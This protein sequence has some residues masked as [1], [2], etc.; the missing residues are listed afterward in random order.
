MLLQLRL[1]EHVALAVPSTTAPEAKLMHPVNG[2][3]HGGC[4]GRGHW[5]S[6]GFAQCYR[7]SSVSYRFGPLHAQFIPSTSR[8][9][10]IPGPFGCAI[11][12][13]R[14]YARVVLGRD[15]P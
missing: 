13:M 6:A 9:G 3:F 11:S 10:V 14:I 4:L 2:D 12:R 1:A 5:L 15:K 8:D 7:A